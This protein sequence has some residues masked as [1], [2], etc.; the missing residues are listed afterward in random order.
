MKAE[1]TDLVPGRFLR[2]LPP[3]QAAK[4]ATLTDDDL[5]PTDLS[6]GDEAPPNEP[7][8]G[9]NICPACEGSGRRGEE[10]CPDCE[11]TGK[12]IEAIGGG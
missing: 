11:G 3:E 2:V 5:K 4:G 1:P 9:E 12:V 6:P 10:Q 7:S 8:A